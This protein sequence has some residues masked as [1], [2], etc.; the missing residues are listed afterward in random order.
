[1]KKDQHSDINTTLVEEKKYR[2]PGTNSFEVKDQNLFFGRDKEKRQLYEMIQLEQLVVLYGKSGLGKTSLLNAGITPQLIKDNYSHYRIRFNAFTPNVKQQESPLENFRSQITPRDD[3]N[4]MLNKIAEND[5]S[6]WYLFKQMQ[7]I[8]PDKKGI[9]LIFDQFEELFTYPTL[10]VEKFKQQLADTL[11]LVMSP[12]FEEVLYNDDQELKAPIHDEEWEQFETPLNVKVVI[13]IRSDKL[14]YLNQ[15]TDYIPNIQK[16]HFQLLPFQKGQAE[17]AI[18]EPAK[19]GGEDY[20]RETPFDFEKDA[21]DRITNHLADK[22]TGAI[23][24]FQL[25]YICEYI[26]NNLQKDVIVSKDL[27]D[28]QDLIGNFYLDKL[29]VYPNNKQ[30]EIIRLLETDLIHAG[31]RSFQYE[32]SITSNYKLEKKD[33]ERLTK[34]RLLRSNKRNGEIFY[35]LTHDTLIPSIIKIKNLKAKK[36]KENIIFNRLFFL[37]VSPPFIITYLIPIITNLNIIQENN[38]QLFSNSIYVS[39]Y[40]NE[41][42]I[43]DIDESLILNLYENVD[44]DSQKKNIVFLINSDSNSLPKSIVDWN[45]TKHVEDTVF[46]QNFEELKKVSSIDL[47][48]INLKY[49][50]PKIEQLN[51]LKSLYLAFNKLDS[52]SF[53]LSTLKTLSQ[54]DIKYNKLNKFPDGITNLKQL[55]M[56]DLSGNNL[57]KTPEGITNLKQLSTLKLSGNNLNKFPDDIISLKQLS[58]LD[59][60]GNRIE[61]L[62]QEISSLKNLKQLYLSKNSLKKIPDSLYE[63][64]KLEVLNLSNT[65]I[66]SI[67]SEIKKLKNLRILSLS[68]NQLSLGSIPKEIYNLPNLKELILEKNPISEKEKISIKNKCS[69]EVKIYF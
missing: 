8:H 28:L 38:N 61:S 5:Q 23:E 31:I 51:T 46:I 19:L 1:M 2:Y 17:L 36:K 65:N 52:L 53:D 54:L 21:L 25:Q 33:L 39:A 30:K 6:L 57:S 29:S 48:S 64:T 40:L 9:V 18:I 56:L 24:T 20:L 4:T 12:N 68:N 22:N 58:I 3:Y 60:S 26:E 11:N 27:G 62:P 59:L 7:L 10:E 49:L 47:S 32:T 37:I 66:S 16:N 44:F 15:M 41:I 35:E 67:S 34:S 63:L 42:L 14:F 45:L 50:S 13:S 69:S 55:S 43:D